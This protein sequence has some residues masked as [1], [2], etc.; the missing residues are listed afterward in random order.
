MTFR[1]EALSRILS[2]DKRLTFTSTLYDF[3]K[4]CVEWLVQRSRAI[5]NL[6]MGM[7]KTIVSIYYVCSMNF[8]RTVVIVPNQLVDQWYNEF[9]KH[10]S[11]TQS[12]IYRY[13]GSDRQKKNYDGIR[14]CIVSYSKFLYDKRTQAIST[15]FDYIDLSDCVI[16]DESH[17][18]R[19]HK[20]QIYSH[21]GGII[22]PT[23][24]IIMLSGTP[25]FNSYKDFTNI[26]K[27]IRMHDS[28]SSIE[29]MKK[30]TYYCKTIKETS[31]TL[32]ETTYTNII[33]QM[34]EYHMAIYSL[35]LYRLYKA[36]FDEDH[37]NA[38]ILTLILR[39]RQTAIHPYC[40][41]MKR[42]LGNIRSNKLDLVFDIA[43]NVLVNTPDDKVIIFSNFNKTFEILSEMFDNAGHD[44]LIFN[45]DCNKKA[46]L[47]SFNEDPTKRILLTNIIA[48]G[49]GLNLQVANNVIFV[50]PYWNKAIQRQA[51]SRVVRIGQQK[52]VNIYRIW[53]NATIETW[54]ADLIDQKKI[55]TERFDEDELYRLDKTL[56]SQILHTFIDTQS[57]NLKYE[58]ICREQLYL[59]R[60]E[61]VAGHK[62]S[63][64]KHEKDQEPEEQEEQTEPEEQIEQEEPEDP[65]KE[66]GTCDKCSKPVYQG[67]VIFIDSMF[68]TYHIECLEI[69]KDVTIEMNKDFVEGLIQSVVSDDSTMGAISDT[70][71][72][73][74]PPSYEEAMGIA[75]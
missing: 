65:S 19:N 45:G 4:A 53:S 72:E 33:C 12:E 1:P 74:P 27:L 20:T 70:S 40:T 35:Y 8:K 32:P 15:L 13:T 63:I 51:E 49:V 67:N 37:N 36:L 56:L 66:I 7:G 34:D 2:Q 42:S 44:T 75:S 25:I 14:I 16:C 18:M 60:L 41:N 9:L 62:F 10:S 28:Q 43:T 11:V 58:D 3:Q 61:N 24:H 59:N 48:G 22:R 52:K 6:E 47:K 23:M 31:L 17:T 64:F 30:K 73:L 21:V 29:E 5:V 57:E 26:L 50:E 68:K 69:S 46:V 39:L 54:M 71:T 38:L 55:V